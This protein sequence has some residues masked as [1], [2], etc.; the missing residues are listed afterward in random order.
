VIVSMGDLAA[1]GGYYIACNADLIIAEPTTITGSIGVFGMLPNGKELA[2]S[3][4]INAEQV[5]TNKNAVS[6]SFFE[7]LSDTQHDYIKE[8]VVDIYDLFTKRVADGRNM[9]QDDVKLIAEGR[10]WTGAEAIN[11]GLV[12]ELGGLD[13]ALE[14]AAEAAGIDTYKVKELPIFEKDLDKI[15][16]DFGLIKTKADILKEELGEENYKMLQKIKSMT[17][18]KGVQ[19]LFPYSLEIK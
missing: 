5:V 10:V 7:P 14:R 13:L 18:K 16:R 11:N 15:L 1:S 3:W 8:S 2:D 12:D 17:E 9:S 6:Y 4:G 19:L